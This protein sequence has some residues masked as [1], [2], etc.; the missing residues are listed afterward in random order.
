MKKKINIG[1]VAHVDAE[2]TTITENLLYHSG[3]II[4]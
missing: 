3:V 1:I 2:K 4:H